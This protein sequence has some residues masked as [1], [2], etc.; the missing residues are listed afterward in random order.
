VVAELRDVASECRLAVA[1][2]RNVMAIGPKWDAEFG[3]V[4]AV[5]RDVTEEPLSEVIIGEDEG[6]EFGAASGL[7]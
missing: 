7:I 4:M 3:D 2:L 5:W 1:E 6:A